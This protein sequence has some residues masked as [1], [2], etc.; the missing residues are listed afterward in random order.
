MTTFFHKQ[1]FMLVNTPFLKSLH[2]EFTC[3]VSI[4]ELN[5]NLV[6]AMFTRT[7]DK[8]VRVSA[9]K[10]L[11]NDIDGAAVG[12][13]TASAAYLP[14]WRQRLPAGPGLLVQR[15]VKLYLACRRNRCTLAAPS[16]TCLPPCSI[17]LPPLPVSPCFVFTALRRFSHIPGWGSHGRALHSQSGGLPGSSTRSS[18]QPWLPPRVPPPPPRSRL[19]ACSGLLPPAPAPVPS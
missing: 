19:P 11:G 4:R 2:F 6:C 1:P 12:G 15:L 3:S 13:G 10:P 9:E 16:T 7:A 5:D 17:H 14:P 18:T 8:T